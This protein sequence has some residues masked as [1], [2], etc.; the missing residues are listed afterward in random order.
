MGRRACKDVIAAAVDGQASEA[1]GRAD[2][3]A[4][5]RLLHQVIHAHVVL[6][7]HQEERLAR[8]EQHAG[9]AAPVLPERVLRRLLAQL[10]DH[11]GLHQEQRQISR[12]S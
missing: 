9:H 3:L 7:R 1:A 2:Q 11:H 8:V 4:S 12:G 10:V 6:R 5:Q